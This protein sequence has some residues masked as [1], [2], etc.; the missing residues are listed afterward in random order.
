MMNPLVETHSDEQ[1]QVLVKASLNGD[2]KALDKLVRI[3]QPFI[4][5]VAWKMAF[6]PDDA[7][8]LTQE[9][10][11]KVITKLSQFNFKSQFRTWLYR[12]V[13]NEFLQ[14]KR[15]KGESKFTTLEDHGARLDAVPG[16]DLTVEEEIEL[17]EL[18][19]E[20]QFRCLSGMLMCLTREQRLIYILG[21]TFE[22]DHNIGSE[23]FEIT[24]QNFRV[25]LHRARKELHNFMDNKCGLVNPSNPCRCSK[26]AKHFHNNG[27]LTED[28]QMFNVGYREK[29]ADYA[30]L[31]HKS[32]A[33]TVEDIHTK[34]FRNHPAKDNFDTETI[35]E[36][37]L[38]DHDLMK[39]FL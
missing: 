35:I 9:V 16:T 10:L 25:K 24:R 26:K 19:K 28:K 23:I 6:E 7:L 14:T 18:T 22:V 8:D 32:V 12:I 34:L 27:F 30:E 20:V 37:I 3:H 17:K 13:V 11:I 31:H 5:N 29:I 4:Y 15:R 39:H 38:S 2:R 36:E 33:D 21:E 1:D